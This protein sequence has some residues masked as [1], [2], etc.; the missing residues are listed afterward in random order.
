MK[1]EQIRQMR[2][3]YHLPG[4]DDVNIQQNIPYKQADGTE[5]CLDIYRPAQSPESTGLPS[6]LIVPSGPLKQFERYP[7]K[8]WENVSSWARLFAASGLGSVTIN[9]RFFSVRDLP[10]ASH[11]VRDAVDYVHTRAP[12]FSLD[13]KRMCLLTFWGGGLLINFALREQP[14]FLRCLVL[15]SPLLDLRELKRYQ[16]VLP[17][18]VIDSYSPVQCVAAI[19]Q[20][21]LPIFLARARS[22]SKQLTASMDAF[23]TQA[24]LQG[25]PLQVA[26]H[27]TGRHAFEIRDDN[28]RTHAIIERTIA[29][30]K[31]HI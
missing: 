2:I 13:P 16:K 23:L 20:P 1:F 22:D 31:E 9:H 30:V 11:D 5:L 17:E 6:V 24:N 18:G 25:V 7:P 3:V 29:F 10:L 26:C 4:M 8:D 28:A 12:A 19:N 21:T 14:E 15:Y 27:E